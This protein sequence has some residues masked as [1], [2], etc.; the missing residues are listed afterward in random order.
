MCDCTVRTD[1]RMEYA[2]AVCGSILVGYT[3]VCT[4]REYRAG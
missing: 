1:G 2:L 4:V 3:Y